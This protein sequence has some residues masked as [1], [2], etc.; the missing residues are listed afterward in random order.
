MESI[1][2]ISPIDG[3][4]KNKTVELSRFC[5]EFG[6]ISYRV[7]VEIEYLMMLSGHIQIGL[8]LFTDEEKFILRKLKNLS[9]EE[10]SIVKQIEESGYGN[11]Q[12]TRHDVKSVEYFLKDFLK[13]SSLSDVLEW[14]HFGLTS[15][16][17]NNISYALMLRDSLSSV[18]L[19]FLENIV[20]EIS[21]FALSNKSVSILARTHGQPASPT[22]FG[23]EFK[24]YLSRLER[25]L[26]IIKKNKILVKLNGATGNY[27]AHYCAYP[28][29][30][31]IKFSTDFVEALNTNEYIKLELNPLTTQIEPQDSFVEIFDALRRTNTI[32][33]DFSQDLW[34]YISDDWL[35][36]K[37]VAG[38]VGS[39]TMPHKVNPIDFENAE[40]NL[41][42]A[43]SF[44][45]FFGQKLPISRLQRDLSSSTVQR[46][47]GVAFSHCLIAYKSILK[48]L[49]KITVNNKKVE[50]ELEKHPE[51]LTE[52]IQTILR[53]EGVKDP[54]EQL[55]KLSRGTGE[56]RLVD[57][58]LF[59]S[60]LEI[61]DNIKRELKCLLPSSYIG[62][63][64]QLTNLK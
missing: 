33:I 46:N 50:D 27:N 21:N 45:S 42:L 41:G 37:T 24:V 36:Q 17:I 5:S 56:M 29:V 43:N 62:L 52:A 18:I 40:G 9:V 35:T 34:R 51:I 32:L 10:A 11:L 31:W 55:K 59:I 49:S 38:E 63:A 60:Q 44:F 1:L 58:H 13:H 16:D 12:P 8:R 26:E 48:G 2:A 7:K 61:N 6:L 53:R 25:Q 3:R 47:F 39:S 22:T 20:Q 30:D 4:Y 57:L 54:Y 19:P 23:K 64:E 15:E 14:I 28:N